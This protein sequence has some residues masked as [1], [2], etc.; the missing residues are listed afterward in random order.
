MKKFSTY[1]FALIFLG[2]CATLKNIAPGYYQAFNAIKVFYTG[3]ESTITSEMIEAIPYSS[4]LL[5]IGNGPV[6]LIIL[7]SIQTNVETWVS[8]DNVYI[9]IQ[10]GK[11][12]KT[13]GLN[14]NL[15]ST[16]GSLSFSEDFNNYIVYLSYDYPE[17]NN[18]ELTNKLT[19]RE[20]QEVE[21][22]SGVKRLTLYEETFENSYL[23]WRGVNQYWID[24][25]GYVLKS[26]QYI[27]TKLPPIEIEVT[28]K[29]AM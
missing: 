18:L 28:K 20:V 2:S 12:I 15:I 3:Y 27:S 4:A 7:E 5:K 14:N 8:A 21:L 6:G 10:N 16:V 25:T 1:L 23:N 13:A 22:L 17:L 11:I 9:Q 29:P 26:K 24:D 19:K